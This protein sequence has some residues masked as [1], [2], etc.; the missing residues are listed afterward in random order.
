MFATTKP[1][2]GVRILGLVE[3]SF[4]TMKTLACFATFSARN[5]TDA[6]APFVVNSRFL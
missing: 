1:K 6:L 5:L 2:S 4:G 3:G